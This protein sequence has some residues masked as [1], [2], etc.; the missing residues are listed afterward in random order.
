MFSV[1]TP[2]GILK[3][4]IML[5]NGAPYVVETKLTQRLRLDVNGLLLDYLS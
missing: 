5:G 1:S 2:T 4:D 3:P